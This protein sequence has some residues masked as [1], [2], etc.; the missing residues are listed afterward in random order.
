[1]KFWNIC[2]SISVTI[3]L[4]EPNISQNTNT[5][6]STRRNGQIHVNWKSKMAAAA[7]LNFGKMSITPDWIKIYAPNFTGRCI[8]AMRRWSRDQKSKPEVNWFF[9][10]RHQ[11][12]VWSITASI[13]VT[14]ACILPRFGT[15]HKCHT[16]N[17]SEWP[18]SQPQNT[19]CR[20]LPSWI[21]RLCEI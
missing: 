5:T 2:A 1:M 9:A 6:P 13:S 3:T 7:I 12:N 21:F 11:M 16:V 18:N 20:L 15:E 4:F 19:R 17:T 10:W 14:I 8:T